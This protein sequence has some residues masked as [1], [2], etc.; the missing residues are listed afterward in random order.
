[1]AET[2]Q[3][4][5]QE[6]RDV[7][8]D[9]LKP[10]QAEIEHG[11]ELHANSLVM[12]SYGF[13]PR[14]APDG[15]AMRAAIEAG[16]TEAELEDMSEDIMMTRGVRD[17]AARK[18]FLEAWDAAGMT[19]I[20]QNAGQEGMEVPRVIKRL[21]HFTW[22]TDMIRDDLFRAVT[23]EDI[24]SA[25]AQGRRCLYLSLNGVPVPLNLNCVEEELRYIGIFFHL[26]ARMAHLLSLI[27]I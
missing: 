20:F 4:R 15:D 26:G 7:A 3:E 13:A 24:A 25:H 19:C 6:A 9:L 21:A 17:A 5:V 12:E 8:L 18:E 22:L 1:M 11:L 14:F 23:P 16:A 10:T 2:V 27:H